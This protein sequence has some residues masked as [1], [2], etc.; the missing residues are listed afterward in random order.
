V[1]YN[2]NE[3]I[4]MTWAKRILAPLVALAIAGGPAVAQEAWPN[5]SVRIVNPTAAGGAHDVISRMLAAYLGQSL[6]QQIV[7]DNRAG[8]SQKIASEHVATARPDGY[9]F[10]WGTP[11]THVYNVIIFKDL[12]YD[13]IRDLV[14]VTLISEQPVV[15]VAHPSLGVR[16]LKDLI[17]LYKANPGKYSY[18]SGGHSTVTHLGPELFKKMAGVEI[19]H[20]PYRGMGPA[21]ADFLKGEVTLLMDGQTNHIRLARDGT[22]V[23]IAVPAQKRSPFMPDVPTF[24][25]AGL[26]GV[27]I[28]AW[29]GLFA[30]RGTP[31]EIIDKMNAAVQRALA[32]EAVS[33]RLKDL[34]AQPLGGSTPE[35]VAA[36]LTK[37]I[38]IWRPIIAAAG[39]KAE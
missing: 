14:P 22:V 10:L 16:T 39:V 23:P 6:G 9:T 25:E 35:T 2:E 7:V 27:E 12:P 20:V 36:F 15:L 3:E 26:P 24:A 19:V 11:A 5:R 17:A 38:E 37:E 8:G 30:P 13:P 4:V 1:P 31:R 21:L 32:D 18:G 34:G 33:N 28:V 29:N